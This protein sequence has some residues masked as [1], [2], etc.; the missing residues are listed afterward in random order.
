MH[1]TAR[2]KIKLCF[3]KPVV[4]RRVL[5]PH[6]IKLPRL[7]DVI[8]VVMGWT[9]SHLHAFRTKDADYQIPFEQDF[10]DFFGDS[11][12][13]RSC[14]AENK[15][16]LS[17]LAPEKG[18]KFVYEYDF[19]DSWEHEVRV[20]KL[21]PAGKRA[22]RAELLAGENACPPDDCGGVS[23]YCDLV[24]ILSDPSDS[25]HERMRE[26]MGLAAGEKFDPAA[27]NPDSIRSRLAKIKV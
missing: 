18:G 4:W 14:H 5:V 22:T 26:W 16:R 24:E 20:E 21:I 6:D 12:D 11:F 8:Q 3:L 25:A 23:G 9:N 10:G 17:D 1:Q 2:L 19:G 27:F 15:F 13:G 7:H